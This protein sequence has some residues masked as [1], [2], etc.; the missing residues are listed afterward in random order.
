MKRFV[1]LLE[2]VQLR[3]AALF[4]VVFIVC[5]ILGVVS[6]YI[7]GVSILWTGDVA[8]YSFIWT[9]FLGASVMVK[10]RKHFNMG[11]LKEKL[12]GKKL[13]I[14]N[15]LIQVII[16]LFSFVIMIDGYK[17]TMQFWDWSLNALPQVK[18]RYIWS[19][20]PVMG[21][22]MIIYSISNLYEDIQSYVKG[23]SA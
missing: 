14:N 7:P 17:L 3:L 15:V 4:L 22:T 5:V 1:N 12:T 23:E 20:M 16:I 18:Q 10:H 2:Y 6:R 8:T 11:A 13:L 19:V 21:A 9:V